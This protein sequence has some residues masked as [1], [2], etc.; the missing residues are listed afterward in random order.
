MYNIRKLK[1][2]RKE[3]ISDVLWV[4]VMCHLIVVPIIFIGGIVKLIVDHDTIG[5]KV[6]LILYSAIYIGVFAYYP[7]VHYVR[8][9]QL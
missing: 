7:I 8:L 2:A 6:A 9:K 5:I 4:L 1:K 3:A